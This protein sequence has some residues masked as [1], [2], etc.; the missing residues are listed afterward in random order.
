MRLPSITSVPQAA[1]TAAAMVAAPGPAALTGSLDHAEALIGPLFDAALYAA[2]YADVVGDAA[3]LLR[4]FCQSG[5][6]EGRNPNRAFDTASY[7]LAHPDVDAHGMNPYYHYLLTGWAEG[8]A[9]RPAAVPSEVAQRA[10]GRSV[11]DWVALLRPAMDVAFYLDRLGFDT[12]GLFDPVAHYAYRGWLEGRD[13]NPRFCVQDA[14]AA[15]PR[16]R[17]M[18][19]NPLLHAVLGHAPEPACFGA[20]GKLRTT[21]FTAEQLAAAAS[22]PRRVATQAPASSLLDPVQ[23]CVAGQLDRAFYLQAYPDVHRHGADPV[24]HYCGVGWSEG[25]NPTATFDTA[26][27]LAANPDVAQLGVNP[28]WHYLVAGQAEGRPPQQPGGSRRRV[29]QTARSPD[30]S[31]AD[32]RPEL[33]NVLSRRQLEALLGAALETGRGLALSVG[34]DRYV[35]VTGGLQLFLCE[36]QAKFSRQ[37]IAYL[38]VSPFNNLLRLADDDQPGPMLN[39]LLD[40][41]LLGVAAMADLAAVLGGLPRRPAQRRLFLVHC[42]LGHKLAD[43]LA[44]QRASGS[45]ENQFWLH[46]Y[47]SL[48]AGYS[49]LRNDVA[50]CAAP[51]PDSMA[52]RVCVY[53]SHR[54]NHLAAVRSLLEAVPF[55][56]VAPSAAALQTW[57]AAGLPHRSARVHAHCR[58]I[59]DLESAPARGRDGPVRVAFIG[60]AKP[61]KGWPIWQD[62]VARCSGSAEYQW[63]HLGSVEPEAALPGVEH[64]PVTTTRDQPE[65]MIAAL[66]RLE[67]DLAAILSPWPETFSYTTFETLAAGADV[68]CLASSGNVAAAVLRHGRGVVAQDAESLIDFFCSGAALRYNQ[69]VRQDG[70]E[71][72]RL[73]HEGTSATLPPSLDD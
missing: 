2:E 26:Y 58:V 68:V 73:L 31:S 71:R 37:G 52:C 30:L 32:R 35:S 57:Q 62:L 64:H 10:L 66:R 38:N 70:T 60:Y 14:L 59:P 13:P 19:L 15:D 65:A 1:A 29:I 12:G 24:A 7:L 8:R 50:F 47:S 25:R 9:V 72:G 54:A 39:L 36:E 27:Y 49:L 40:G 21:R 28:F 23:Q 43:M 6:R 61:H 18:R 41:A 11:G 63:L 51:P 53:G 4:H 5:W 42:L 44:L 33:T 46:D 16:L 56:V 17:Q 48:C 20:G 55:H 45:T 34:H 69:H 22:P 3:A 67:V